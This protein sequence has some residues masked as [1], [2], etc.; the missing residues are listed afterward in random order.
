MATARRDYY[1]VL[2]VARD[3]DERELKRAFR[4]LARERHPDVSDDP[5]AEHKFREVAEAYEVL[6]KPETRDLYDRYGHDG[7][8]TGGY[9]PSHADVGDL[10]DLISSF[11]GGDLFGDLFGAAGARRRR[12]G[13]VLV[14]SE[15]T[16]GEAATGVRREIVYGAVEPC[17]TCDGSGAEPGSTPETCTVC[18]GAGRLQQVSGSP[19]GQLVRTQL[20]PRCHGAGRIVTELCTACGGDGHV[21]V[22]RRVEV[23][24][25]PGIHDGQRIRV[26]GQGHANAGLGR[27]GDLYVQVGV[28]EHDV[29]ARDGDDVVAE[30]DVTL[31][32][33]AL[34]A[35]V[36][37]PTLDGE[38]EVEL[39]AGTQPGEVLVLRGKG[40]PVLQGRGRG[41]Q[42]IVVNVL[43]PR[44][45]TDE[46]RRAL[47]ELDRIVGPEAYEEPDDGFLG[48]IR[49]AFR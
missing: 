8:R 14:R 37:V 24:I 20:C 11:F 26:A 49:S 39:P 43:V 15:V 35:R 44:R 33:A 12:G 47:E 10:S 2:G 9:R 34:G 46:Q 16:L 7:L 38:A 29:L 17:P 30:V 1:E 48:R 5:E 19:F 41:D 4:Q 6:S 23:A 25:P 45:L 28:L 13:D 22:E 21:R 31:M 3:A 40:L 42:R 32:Q 18:A 27:R 36:T